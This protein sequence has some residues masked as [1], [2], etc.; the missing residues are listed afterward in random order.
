MPS[1]VDAQTAGAAAKNAVV[2]DPGSWRSLHGRLDAIEQRRP[3]GLRRHLAVDDAERHVERADRF[4]HVADEQAARRQ[5]ARPRASFRDAHATA[6]CR[7]ARAACR[8]R[9]PRRA[10]R[11]SIRAARGRLPDPVVPMRTGGSSDAKPCRPRAGS[12]AARRPDRARLDVDRPRDISSLGGGRP[13]SA[14]S[15]RPPRR[16][17]AQARIRPVLAELHGD[18]MR[19]A[20]RRPC[21]GPAADAHARDAERLAARASAARP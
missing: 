20:E 12:R 15:A 21:I 6:R 3:R 14:R 11:P 2:S 19:E 16:A 17:V 7:S 8:P 9:S 13:S 10:A 18:P 4:D 5:R 1:T